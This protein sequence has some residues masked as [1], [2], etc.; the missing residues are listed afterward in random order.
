MMVYIKLGFIPKIV[1]Q[2]FNSKNGIPT[3]IKTKRNKSGFKEL[4]EDING[5]WARIIKGDYTKYV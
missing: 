4:I 5:V 1:F 3:I 2:S